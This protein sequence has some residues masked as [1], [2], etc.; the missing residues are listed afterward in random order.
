MPDVPAADRALP[1]PAQQLLAAEVSPAVLEVAFVAALV[2]H[3]RLA[4]LLAPG[5]RL[6]A[7]GSV[8]PGRWR[9]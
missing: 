3:H 5:A 8:R 6:L 2:D 9:G 4:P 7:V 1:E